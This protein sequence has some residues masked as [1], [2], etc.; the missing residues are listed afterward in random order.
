MHFLLNSLKK[1]GAEYAHISMDMQL[2]MIACKIKWDDLQKWKQ[3]VVHPG[4]MHTLMSFLGCIG[5][6]MK[7][8][9]M[10]TILATTFGSIKG[11]LNGKSWPQALRAYRM[12]TAA[13]IIIF[14]ESNSICML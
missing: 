5:F 4:M 2:F 1:I 3:I 13:L 7:G 14:D 12:L 8:S 9:G 10:E 11:I 6:L